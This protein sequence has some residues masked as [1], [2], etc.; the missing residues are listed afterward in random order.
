MSAKV[1]VI[2]CDRENAKRGEV[3]VVENPRTAA[4]LV[5]TLLEA[6]FEQGRI[7]LF[8]GE[9]TEMRVTSRPVVSLVD[10]QAEPAA[11]PALVE[12]PSRPRETTAEQA[13]AE[14]V[15]P[16]VKDGVRFSSLF[17]AG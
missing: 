14:E 2:V 15:T 16:F 13:S 5:E 1:I 12:A 10:E 4:H 17:R 9:A 8:S 7:R 11:G 3:T 6:G